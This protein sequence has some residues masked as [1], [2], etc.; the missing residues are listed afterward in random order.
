[1][2]TSS[3]HAVLAAMLAPAFFL[4]ATA[5]L[6]LSANNRLA[7]IIDRARTLLRELAEIDDE[8]ERS[9]LEKR[10]A[11]QRLR[12]LTILRVGQ[13]LYTAISF[14]VGTSLAVAVDTFTDHRLGALPL[15]LASLGV[16][17]MFAASL[18]LARESTLAVTAINEEMDHR[19]VKR[20]PPA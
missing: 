4:T 6:L 18:L 17:A 7:R 2:Y 8:A 10:I 14:F 13:L 3:T 1:M 5:S 16:L 11:L 19:P 12:S 9:L 15:W 20:T